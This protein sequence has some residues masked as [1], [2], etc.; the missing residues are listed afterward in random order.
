MQRFI[1]ATFLMILFSIV[2]SG[3][4]KENELDTMDV[5]GIKENGY[6]W[7]D[8]N[9]Y[10]LSHNQ[11]YTMF[12]E[13]MTFKEGEIRVLVQEF[14]TFLSNNPCY[15]RIVYEIYQKID[16]K[17]DSKVFIKVDPTDPK[18]VADPRL[19]ARYNIENKTIIYREMNVTSLLGIQRID[20]VTLIH[21][22]MHHWQNLLFGKNY[23]QWQYERNFEFE[24]IFLLDVACIQYQHK[25]A[26]VHDEEDLM[27]LKHDVNN[28]VTY[29][30]E[31]INEYVNA[32]N[33]TLFG[34]VGDIKNKLDTLA[35]NF[36]KY[37]YAVYTSW[38]EFGLINFLY[39][40]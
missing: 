23:L 29:T 4:L 16:K 27:Y 7:D 2:F 9:Q 12:K 26:S 14:E 28:P 6:I 34:G 25:Y 10:I 15:R 21:E 33:S 5:D 39:K 19:L 13:T 8:P 18:L 35:K 38:G 32:I 3:C 36:R 37:N 1:F 31:E 22:L 24:V 20:F 40:R 30:P 17:K 11:L